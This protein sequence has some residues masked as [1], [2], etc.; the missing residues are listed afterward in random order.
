MAYILPKTSFVFGKILNSVTDDIVRRMEYVSNIL[1]KS[2]YVGT[3]SFIC[4]YIVEWSHNLLTQPHKY[5]P[6]TSESPCFFHSVY[7]MLF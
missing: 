3:L 4:Q 2:S 1:Y 6:K 5:S 7:Y